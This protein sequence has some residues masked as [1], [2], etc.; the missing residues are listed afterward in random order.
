M[1]KKDHGALVIVE[2]EP[3]LLEYVESVLQGAGHDTR[4]AQS[5]AEAHALV[6]SLDSF[7]LVFTDIVLRDHKYGGV[8][9]GELATERRP[10]TPVLYTSGTQSPLAATAI[11]KFLQKPYRA[12]SLL[13]A[14]ACLLRRKGEWHRTK[15]SLAPERKSFS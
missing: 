3:L 10:G 15:S 7:D 5:L 4:S 8:V 12:Q 2:D 1:G 6:Q 11:G 14:V 13:E 9:V